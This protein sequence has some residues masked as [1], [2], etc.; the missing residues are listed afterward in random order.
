MAE[1]TFDVGATLDIVTGAELTA[2]T[3]KL[4]KRGGP[5]KF[6][7]IR[8]TG[9]IV[10]VG[11]TAVAQFPIIC[12]GMPAG[13]NAGFIWVLDSAITFA[14]D[15]HTLYNPTP[16]TSFVGAVYVG[17]NT[18]NNSLAE[19]AVSGF[20]FPYT[21][22]FPDGQY[23]RH[24]EAITVQTSAALASGQQIGMNLWGRQF[25]ECDIIEMSGR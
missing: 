21:F 3:D 18:G 2:H 22:D 14:Q 5:P 11:G 13:P 4:M 17:A 15:D 23:V 10:G 20:T 25:R 6:A 7:L 16:G 19:L 1:L 9:S 8:G 12:Q 24:G